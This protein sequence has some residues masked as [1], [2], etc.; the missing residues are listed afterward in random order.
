MSIHTSAASPRRRRLPLVL[1]GL[2]VGMIGAAALGVLRADRP[3]P[4]LSS[5]RALARAKQFDRAM[6]QLEVYLRSHPHD[7]A[8]HLL[9]GQIA[10]EPPAPRPEVALE[11]MAAA[12]PRGPKE[13]ARVKFIEG[14]A[15][16]YQGRYDLAE[17]AWGEALRLDPVVAEAGWALVDLLD[18]E[19]RA[20]EAHDLSMRLIEVEPDPLDRARI[21]L[22]A[23]R[24]D[25]EVPNPMSLTLMFESFAQQHPENLPINLALGLGLIRDSRG[26]EGLEVLEGALRRHP[27][28]PEAWDAWLTGLSEAYRAERLAEEFARLPRAMADDP[29]FVKHEGMVAQNARDWPRAIRAFRRA[30]AIEPHSGPLWYRLRA[31]L[32]MVGDTAELDR[33]NR[34]YTSFEEAYK[35]MRPTYYEALAVPTLGTSPHPELYHR[36]AELR[37]RMGRPD[38]ARAWHR[39]VLRDAPSDPTSLAALDRLK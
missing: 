27:G 28:S 10:T 7:A 6:E 1:A 25:F 9:M 15:Q 36:L 24:R 35:Q 26:A 21:L 34:W 14:K 3:G 16:Y 31:A 8:A 23:A 18:K 30:A 2:M 32:R 19:G 20:A 4:S 38:E 37:E 39:M 11:H 17:A 13:A 5:V 33:V 12:R 29:R 22:D